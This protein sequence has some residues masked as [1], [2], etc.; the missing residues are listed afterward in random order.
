MNA[1]LFPGGYGLAH[2]LPINVGSADK[3]ALG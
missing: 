1:P 2:F 3:N